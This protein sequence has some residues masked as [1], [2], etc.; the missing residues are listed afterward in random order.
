MLQVPVPPDTSELPVNKT[1]KVTDANWA[2]DKT[3]SVLLLRARTLGYLAQ[4]TKHRLG[5]QPDVITDGNP[6]ALKPSYSPSPTKPG[7]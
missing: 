6:C 2:E 4:H 5:W 1:G 3:W 7:R